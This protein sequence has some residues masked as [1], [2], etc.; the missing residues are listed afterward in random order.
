M[1]LNEHSQEF[2]VKLSIEDGFIGGWW[3]STIIFGE[4]NEIGTATSKQ[5]A[6]EDA[7]DKIIQLLKIYFPYVENPI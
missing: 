2:D 1:L 4:Y 3:T 7:S 6:R 5:M